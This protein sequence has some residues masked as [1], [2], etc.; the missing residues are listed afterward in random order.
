M[1]KRG[2][3]LT[4]KTRTRGYELSKRRYVK[5][6]ADELDA[7]QLESTHTIDIDAFVPQEEIDERYLARPYY[8]AP[9]GKIGADALA[10]I[11]DDESCTGWKRQRCDVYVYFDNDQK[12]AAPKDALRLKALL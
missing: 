7:V 4:G 12:S 2:A 9:G 10:V 8:I 1:R 3:S 6:E 5:I 11:R